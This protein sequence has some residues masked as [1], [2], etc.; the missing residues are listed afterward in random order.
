LRLNRAGMLAAS[1]V[2]NRV[3]VER[4]KI[5]VFFIL[6]RPGDRI[7]IKIESESQSYDCGNIDKK[8]DP[9][10]L[11]NRVTEFVYSSG[12][13]FITCLFQLWKWKKR[14][15]WLK[16]SEIRELCKPKN[17]ISIK[18]TWILRD[19][20]LPEAYRTIKPTLICGEYI[21]SFD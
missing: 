16:S 18:V 10:V 21:H 4:W 8:L 20:V 2:L 3:G 14:W 6:W 1:L 17:L 19:S 9:R 13:L 15:M 11:L 7:V 5:I 12:E